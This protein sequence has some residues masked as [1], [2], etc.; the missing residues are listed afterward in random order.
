ITCDFSFEMRPMWSDRNRV[1]IL[2]ISDVTSPGLPEVTQTLA[3]SISEM[4]GT[5]IL[6]VYT[7]LKKISGQITALKT[8]NRSAVTPFPC[9]AAVPTEGHTRTETLPGF[10]TLDKSSRDADAGFEPWTFRSVVIVPIDMLA[11]R[12]LEVESCLLT[13]FFFVLPVSPVCCCMAHTSGSYALPNPSVIN[14]TPNPVYFP[15]SPVI[16][17]K[18][19]AGTARYTA[20]GNNQCF[21]MDFSA[22][23]HTSTLYRLDEAMEVIPASPTKSGESSG[24]GV[25]A[26]LFECLPGVVESSRPVSTTSSLN[27]ECR[28]VQCVNMF[29][30]KLIL[31]PFIKTDAIPACSDRPGTPRADE[32][33]RTG[34]MTSDNNHFCS[35]LLPNGSPPNPPIRNLRHQS[36]PTDSP[37]PISAKYNGPRRQSSPGAQRIGEPFS[38]PLPPTSP[39]TAAAAATTATTARNTSLTSSFNKLNIRGRCRGTNGVVVDML[40]R[41]VPGTVHALPSSLEPIP[42]GQELLVNT[43]GLSGPISPTSPGGNVGARQP[44]KRVSDPAQINGSGTRR[45]TSPCCACHIVSE[46][47]HHVEARVHLEAVDARAAYVFTCTCY[48]VGRSNSVTVLYLDDWLRQPS[49]PHY[50]EEFSVVLTVKTQRKVT[51]AF[52]N[53]HLCD[54]S[55]LLQAS[56]LYKFNHSSVEEDPPDCERDTANG[57]SDSRNSV[58]HGAQWARDL[59]GRLRSNS[60]HLNTDQADLRS[61]TPSGRKPVA[62][63]PGDPNRSIETLPNGSNLPDTIDPRRLPKIHGPASACLQFSKKPLN[64]PVTNHTLPSSSQPIPMLNIHGSHISPVLKASSWRHRKQLHRVRWSKEESVSCSFGQFDEDHVFSTLFRHSTCYDVLPDSGKLVM[65][66]S[67]LGAI[68]AIRVLLENGVQAAPIWHAPTHSVTGLFSQELALHL[69]ASL[70]SSITLA[71]SSNQ[72]TGSGDSGTPAK[73]ATAHNSLTDGLRMWGTRRLCEV[74]RVFHTEHDHGMCLLDPFDVDVIVSPRTRLRKALSR[75]LHR[76][77][78]LNSYA[79]LQHSAFSD[80]LGQRNQQL[81]Q[82]HSVDCNSDTADCC[83]AMDEANSSNGMKPHQPLQQVASTPV[84]VRSLSDSTKASSQF[85]IAA[86]DIF[87]P[88]HLMVMDPTSGNVLGILGPDRLLA[89]LRLR[90]DELP[91]STQMLSSVDSIPGLRWSER[92]WSLRHCRIKHNSSDPHPAADLNANLPS[93]ILSPNSLCGDAIRALSIWLPQLP[94]LPVICSNEGATTQTNPLLGFISPGDL[95]HFVLGYCPDQAVHQ[96]VSKILEAKLMTK[97]LAFR[98]IEDIDDFLKRKVYAASEIHSF[99]YQFGF[100]GKLIWN[101]DESLVYDIFTLHQAAGFQHCRFHQDCICYT[102]DLIADALDRTFRLKVSFLVFATHCVRF[103][104]TSR[105]IQASRI[106]VP[107]VL[108]WR[109]LNGVYEDSEVSLIVHPFR[110]IDLIS[111]VITKL[112][113]MDGKN[114]ANGKTEQP[115]LLSSHQ[116][117]TDSTFSCSF[118]GSEGSQTNVKFISHMFLPLQRSL[119]G[120]VWENEYPNPRTTMKCTHA[121]KLMPYRLSHAAINRVALLAAYSRA[122]LALRTDDSVRLASALRAASARHMAPISSGVRKTHIPRLAIEKR[123]NPEV[124]RNYQNQLLECLPDGTVSDINGHW[125]KISKALIKVRTS[126][127]GL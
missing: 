66:D 78:K 81:V 60:I 11:C 28:Y 53:H 116:M 1:V 73:S 13:V 9:L 25:S 46:T 71:D 76:K 108:V 92:S 39:V 36:L 107:T 83:F 57:K 97:S 56:R 61:A 41:S 104:V 34:F 51:L 44:G 119:A 84:G 122:G 113:S 105:G 117:S 106:L 15:L 102:H 94:A 89:Y 127:C 82:H 38:S 120:S 12:L 62:V 93:P 64:S 63:R 43:A 16:P 101:P 75:L 65:V 55:I 35:N 67:R 121:S 110:V 2:T 24:I 29:F 33:N 80:A 10:P 103:S 37:I 123:V 22:P 27:S 126:V 111:Y 74:L 5:S 17:R 3:S 52:T 18:V 14:T 114:P 95:L 72:D 70:Y 6:N 88:T 21:P 7:K 8:N 98:N 50:I 112:Y 85:P 90:L 77:S 40:A 42:Q 48:R 59:L 91:Y 87:S 20:T 30:Q 115:R 23:S 45:K 32:S 125:E 58:K 4:F 47:L 86:N 68:R 69:L 124:K 26:G 79:S 49:T 100:D 54:V 96:P 31:R 19:N 109:W 99:A 118:K